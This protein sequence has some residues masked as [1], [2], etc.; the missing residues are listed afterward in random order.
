MSSWL[1]ELDSPSVALQTLHAKLLARRSVAKINLPALARRDQGFMQCFKAPEGKTFVSCDFSSLEPSIT[2]H[3]SGDKFYTYA[4]Y[5]GI[6]QE[7]WF[8]ESGTLM[9]DDIYLMTASRM[10]G[11]DTPI[12]SFFSSAENRAL[13]VSNKEA[14]T[15][16]KIVKPIRSKAK[17]AC[18]GFGYGMRARK[19]VKQ[20]YDAGMDV[21]YDQAKGM[22]DAYWEVFADVQKFSKTLEAVVKKNGTITNPFGY[23]L[24]PEPHKAFNAFIQSS[25]SGVV[26]ILTMLLFPKLKNASLVA[27]VHDELVYTIPDTQEDIELARQAQ[28]D[29]VNELNQI[30]GFNVPMRLSFTV[31][32]T[33]AE[34][35]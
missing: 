17:P 14:V 1:P 6:G 5:G 24:T 7:P 9:A 12:H 3:F 18:L 19:F 30:L 29:A 13:W 2:A 28:I 10:P 26:D 35:K 23:R 16:H 15:G 8:H 33:F 25:A 32:R 11:L 20:A 22:Y 4:C 21:S 31:A 27:I 34:I